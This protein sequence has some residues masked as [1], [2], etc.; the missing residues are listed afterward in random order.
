MGITR[1]SLWDGGV[2]TAW[3]LPKEPAKNWCSGIGLEMLLHL[4]SIGVLLDN[5][6]SC[7]VLKNV[8]RILTQGLHWLLMQR[9]KRRLLRPH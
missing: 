3:G 4:D 2:A 1:R 5:V 6:G 7:C 8:C 9:E